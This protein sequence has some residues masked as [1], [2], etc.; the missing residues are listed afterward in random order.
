MGLPARR[1]LGDTRFPV[2][3][4][5][6]AIVDGVEIDRDAC[7]DPEFRF[8]PGLEPESLRMLPGGGQ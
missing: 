3:A 8:A 2:E 5:V 6:A 4:S 1:A 7:L